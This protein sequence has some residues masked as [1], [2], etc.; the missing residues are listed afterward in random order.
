V[1]GTCSSGRKK[2]FKDKKKRAQFFSFLV[3]FFL[4]YPPPQFLDDKTCVVVRL[5]PTSTKTSKK[6][7]NFF[8]FLGTV[9]FFLPCPPSQFWDDNKTPLVTSSLDQTSWKKRT[10][11]FLFLETADFLSYVLILIVNFETIRPP[12]LQF[13]LSNF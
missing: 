2:N 10:I 11:F 9:G 3:D 12:L 8:L 6:R 13:P 7:T 5:V 1:Y 4:P